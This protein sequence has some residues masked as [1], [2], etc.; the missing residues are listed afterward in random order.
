EM[1][2]GFGGEM[3]YRPP[4]KN[5]A[6]GTE[7][8]YV[9]QRKFNQFFGLQD[10]K[11]LTGYV[12][13]YVTIP[14]A[15]VDASV[16]VGRYLAKDFGVTFDVSRTFE[17]GVRVGAFATFTDVSAEEFGEGRFDKGIYLILPLDLLYNK[18]VRSS[19]GLAY[20]PLIRDGGQQLI[21]R[22]P[23]IGTTDPA[24]RSNLVNSWS[25]ITD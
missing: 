9:Q 11:V 10:Y 5:W 8:S 25:G 21:I 3:L 17:S 15:R 6:I 7:L 24:R 12:T 4:T 19:I 1:F 22:Q 2:A 20:R 13:G 23:L 18:H 14:Q 16:R